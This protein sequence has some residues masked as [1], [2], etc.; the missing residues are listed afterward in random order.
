MIEEIKSGSSLKLKGHANTIRVLKVLESKNLLIS[1]GN[2]KKLLVWDYES[3][4]RL[5]TFDNLHKGHIIALTVAKDD[6]YFITGSYD[7]QL[8]IMGVDINKNVKI[9]NQL[10]FTNR[11]YSICLSKNGDTLYCGGYN[12][13]FLRSWKSFGK[14]EDSSLQMIREEEEKEEKE[15]KES[16]MNSLL[17]RVYD[18]RDPSEMDD[19][20]LSNRPNELQSKLFEKVAQNLEDNNSLVNVSINENNE[21]N[22]EKNFPKISKKMFFSQI[23]TETRSKSPNRYEN[24]DITRLL[25]PIEKT[26]GLKMR[27]SRIQ[28]SKADPVKRAHERSLISEDQKRIF[29]SG[30][31]RI[32]GKN[33]LEISKPVVKDNRP[34]K[35]LEDTLESEKRF[36]SDVKEKVKKIKIESEEIPECKKIKNELGKLSIDIQIRES[37]VMKNRVKALKMQSDLINDLKKD[38][39]GIYIRIINSKL[40]LINMFWYRKMILKWF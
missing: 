19:L 20:Y 9:M 30:L 11:V 34:K 6:S 22:I 40:N 16:L 39:Q 17:S 29:S 27:E 5:H 7:G 8:K 36:L 23:I 35:F 21:P 3:K 1:A 15:E 32:L 38:H 31:G 25:E 13:K 12:K 2:D 4:R 37:K 28:D 33:E 26:F 10:S 24:S 14:V 18:T